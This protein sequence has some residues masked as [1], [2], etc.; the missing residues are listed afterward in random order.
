MKKLAGKT[1]IVTGGGRGIGRA[2][3]LECAAQGAGVVV[4]A[5]CGSEIEETVALI[6]QGG[7]DALAVPTDVTRRE[8]VETMVN[9][10]LKRFGSVDVLVNNA[11]SFRSI[12]GL[13][14][15]DP[16]QWWEDVTVNLLGPMLC[17]RA[18]LPHM[19]ARNSGV[20]ININGGGSTGP[21]PGGSGYGCS[22]AAL[23]R[24]TDT[25]AGELERAGSAVFVCALG[26]G[27]VKTEMTKYQADTPQGRQ[28]IPGSAKSLQ[29]GRDA[30]PFDCAR[31]VVTL[32]EIA[33]PELNGRIFGAN[34]NFYQL[35]E[36]RAEIRNRDG[37]TM[38][39]RE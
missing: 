31:A 4:C 10:A 11:G 12:G 35:Y 7:G 16:D 30:S 14:E 23:L 24:L 19:M 1:V 6:T 37:R 17:S 38:R 33:C 26:P 36:M 28:W 39:F 2:I 13:W 8:P 9:A 29:E 3:A 27:F 22:K 25:L 5:R 15:V 34:N 21:L 20:I 32:V 18:V